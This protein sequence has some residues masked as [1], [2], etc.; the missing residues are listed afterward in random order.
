MISIRDYIDKVGTVD[1]KHL[2]DHFS[3]DPF[4]WSPDTT[5]YIL[6]AMLRGGLL[7]LKVSGREVTAAGQQAIDALKTN[8]SFKQIGVSLRDGGPSNE[9][10][11]RAAKR[12][13]DLVGDTV[14]PL[15]QQISK[16]A[17]KHFPSLQHE[18][19]SLAERLAGLGLAGSDRITTMNRDIADL[20]AADASDATQRLGADTSSIYDN[21]KWAAEAKRALDNG[22]NDTLRDLQAHRREIEGLPDTGVPGELRREV[23]QDLIQF[24]DRLKTTDF[25]KHGPDFSSLLTHLKDQVRQA[26]VI[27]AERQKRTLTEGVQDL[28]RVPEWGEHTQ[29]EQTNAVARLDGLVLEATQDLAGLKQ[30]LARDY[31]INTTVEDIRRSV[32][33]LGQER[34]RQRV[35]EERAKAGKGAPSRLSESISVPAVARATADLDKVIARL[36]EV[37]AQADLYAEIEIAFV[38]TKAD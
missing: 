15:E 7:K 24:A 13:S 22:L 36:G 9:M 33:R 3:S 8:V 30:L 31:D 21:L 38:V 6:A 34:R 29:E 23:H 10:L 25:F 1:G 26:T 4:G 17:A 19:G 28:Q 20:L 32:Q 27:L 14:I 5:R 18:Y 35:E 37:K 12:L 2:L 16:A 11:G